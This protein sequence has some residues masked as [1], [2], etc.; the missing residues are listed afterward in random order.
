MLELFQVAD[1]TPEVFWGGEY[2]L[3]VVAT[4]DDGVR[5]VW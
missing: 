4:L 1:V 3:L 2:H 5:V